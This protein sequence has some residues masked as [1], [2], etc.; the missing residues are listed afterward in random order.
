[1]KTG[2]R[3]LLRVSL[4]AQSFPSHQRLST[5]ECLVL[6]GDFWADGQKLLAGDFIAG[7]EGNEPDAVYTEGGVNFF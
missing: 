2:A 4:P 5:E 6:S 1:M 7:R 3:C